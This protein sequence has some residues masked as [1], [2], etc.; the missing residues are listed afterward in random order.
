MQARM[1][2]LAAFVLRR[3]GF[4]FEDMLRVKERDNPKFAFLFAGDPYHAA[5]RLMA[6]PALPTTTAQ[7]ALQAL[8]ANLNGSASSTQNAGS[9]IATSVANAPPTLTAAGP[10]PGTHHIAVCIAV[11]LCEHCVRARAAPVQL[12]TIHVVNDA[13]FRL[14]SQP[15]WAAQCQCFQAAVR[16]HLQTMVRA[17]VAAGSSGAVANVLKVWRDNRAFD[18]ETLSQLTPLTAANVPNAG[19]GAGAGAGTLAPAARLQQL[20][21]VSTGI[22]HGLAP[23]AVSVGLMASCIK[24]AVGSGVPRWSPVDYATLAHVP[25]AIEPGRLDA[26]VA[27]FYRALEGEERAA[28]ADGANEEGAANH[29]TSR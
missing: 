5:Y 10:G 11:A 13:L 20:L 9:W 4:D 6:R 27:A 23:A 26:R 17:A 3:A 7:A 12:W 21:P 16:P 29:R 8:L 2:K 15:H 18:E 22:G 19:A 1:S 14:K 28:A 25:P 24:Q